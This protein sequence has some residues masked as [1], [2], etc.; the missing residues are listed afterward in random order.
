MSMWQMRRAAALVAIAATAGLLATAAPAEAQV[1]DGE[2]HAFGRDQANTKYSPLDQITAD[3]FLDLEVAWRWTSLSRAVAEADERI[4]PSGYKG[5]PLVVD[6]MIYAIT[7]LG[8]VAAL[9]AGTGEE[10]WT[11]DPRIYDRME[12][13]PNTGWRHRGVSYWKDSESGDARIVFSNHDLRLVAL[14]AKTGEMYPDFGTSGLCRPARRAR[15]GD[16]SDA[17]DLLVAGRHRG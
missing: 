11:Y 3:N 10:V 15:A 6:G 1:P 9:D 17:D 7:A 4:L 8:Q 2:W 5:T 12:R 16:R 13:P 14:N